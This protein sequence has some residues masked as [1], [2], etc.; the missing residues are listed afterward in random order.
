MLCGLPVKPWHTSTPTS[1]PSL[2]NGSAPGITGT[3][4]LL[5]LLGWSGGVG[6]GIVPRGR[7]SVERCY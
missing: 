1:P 4:A 2:L 7:G 5:G 6:W 3:R